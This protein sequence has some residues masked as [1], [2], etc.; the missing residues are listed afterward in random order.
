LEK[1]NEMLEDWAEKKDIFYLDLVPLFK[2]EYEA[3]GTE[4]H[5]LDDGHWSEEGHS[6]AAEQMALWI[7]SLGTLTLK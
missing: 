5:L 4:H 3:N 7:L 1:P 2:E 6:L